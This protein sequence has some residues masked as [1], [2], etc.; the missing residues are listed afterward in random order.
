MWHP[1]LGLN[2]PSH[3]LHLILDPKIDHKIFQSI[4][5]YNVWPYGGI[6]SHIP[7][8]GGQYY[9]FITLYHLRAESNSWYCPNNRNC[10][11]HPSL[12]YI[13]PPMVYHLVSF[14]TWSS[15]F[16]IFIIIIIHAWFWEKR[17]FSAAVSWCRM[18]E[19]WWTEVVPDVVVVTV[20]SV[21]IGGGW[22]VE[23][24]KPNLCISETG[25]GG[26]GGRLSLLKRS[27]N[28][29]PFMYIICWWDSKGLVSGGFNFLKI[30]LKFSILTRIR[31]GTSSAWFA[32]S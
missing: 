11:G 6:F 13:G 31:T 27:V 16:V 5:K 23:G 9:D 8:G 26:G 32:A 18:G 22:A 2:K 12:S 29:L 10:T 30:I 3:S 17:L 25:G 7:L 21:G 19:D 20:G 28:C 1:R 24:L 14:R 15:S 4:H